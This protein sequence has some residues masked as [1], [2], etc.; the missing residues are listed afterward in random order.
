MHH[1]CS[2]ACAQFCASTPSGCEDIAKKK[3]GAK[4]CP[5]RLAGGAEAVAA[6]PS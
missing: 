2:Y 4:I 6:A 1:V 3:M 5:Q